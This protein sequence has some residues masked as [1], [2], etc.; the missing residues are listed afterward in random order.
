M[1]GVHRLADGAGGH[2]VTP[3]LYQAL[4]RTPAVT[5]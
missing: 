5:K 2:L 3:K 4:Q 1:I